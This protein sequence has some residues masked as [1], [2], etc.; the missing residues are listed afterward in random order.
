MTLQSEIAYFKLATFNINGFKNKKL[1]IINFV[2]HYEI[3]ILLVQETWLKGE[4]FTFPNYNIFRNDRSLRPLGGTMVLVK[5]NI[6][7]QAVPGNCPHIEGTFIRV[8]TKTKWVHLGSV[9]CSPAVEFDGTCL[10][11][12]F[13]SNNTMIVGGDLNAKHRIWGCRRENNRGRVLFNKSLDYN[14]HIIPPKEH[15]HS[16]LIGLPEILD[17]FVVKNTDLLSQPEALCDLTSDHLP[18]LIEYGNPLEKGQG[19]H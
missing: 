8:K 9:Y 6:I 11:K 3:D 17:I 12:I 16:S 19:C 13:N 10:G 1:E 4:R 7:A 5:K 2:E 15:T 14:Y 18:V